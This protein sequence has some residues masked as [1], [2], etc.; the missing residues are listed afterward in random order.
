MSAPRN[1]AIVGAS[2]AGLRT[3]EALRERGYDGALTLIGEEKHAPYDRPPLSKQVLKGWV[4]PMETTLPRARTVGAVWRLGTRA[5]RLDRE[6][7]CIETADGDRISYDRVVIATGTRARAWPAP[8]EA[9]LRGMH[10]LRTPED[11]VALLADLDASPSRVLVIGAGFTGSE[12]A[13]VCRDRGLAVTVVELN[14][15]PLMA[16]F[17]AVV[18]DFVARRQREAGVDLRCGT[19]VIGI[20]DNGAG[21]VAGALLSDGHTIAADVVVVCLGAVRNTEWLDGAGL[22]AGPA[23]CVCDSQCHALDR[24]GVPVSDVFV[25]GDIARFRHPLSGDRLVSLEHWG[26]AVD[27][28]KIVAANMLNPGSA[29]NDATLPRFWSMQFGVGLKASGL[30]A[31][32]D[33]VMIVQG[34][35][36]TG[37]FVA[38]YGRQGRMVGAVAA[39]QSRWMS[40]YDEQIIADSHF[41]LEFRLVDQPAKPTPRPAEFPARAA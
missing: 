9:A 18:G 24:M 19:A 21:R 16:A 8:A 3:A 7:Q 20:L 13:S 12:V 17:G 27:Q 1:V 41:P 38:A 23:G 37:R 33:E 5:T 26:T 36:D 30:P 2:L 29:S 32:A 28:A 31:C 15:T 14:A 40:F 25:C 39:N 22:K 35:F 4:G 11:A 34:S 6:R 10:T